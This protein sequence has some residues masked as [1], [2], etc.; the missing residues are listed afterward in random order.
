MTLRRG[1][2]GL[3]F[4]TT[5]KTGSNANPF[6]NQN[7]FPF[8]CLDFEYER[9]SKTE[10]AMAYRSGRHV[11]E[12]TIETQTDY[13]V[14]V[15]TQITNWHLTGLTRGQIE[16]TLSGITIPQTKR[17]KVNAAGKILDSMIT[18]NMPII[19]S[20]EAYGPWGQAG[21]IP[22]ASIAVAAGEIQLPTTLANATVTYM[23]DR[24]MT[25]AKG[26]GGPGSLTLMDK[27]QCV[28]YVKDNSGGIQ[29]SL[30]WIPQMYR[31]SLDVALK[32]TGKL[33]EYE[34]EFV[35]QIPAGWEE[36]DLEIDGQSI[37]WA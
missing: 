17:A 26:Y 31:K 25:T 19:A 23:F 10:D 34:M 18:A 2:T 24:T 9:K 21:A 1:L 4:A 37:V 8:P 33:I 6:L 20:I 29:D 30:I 11:I 16:R 22:T 35:P 28:A 3:D 14:K 5:N 36:P 7:V 32:F 15:K 13:T 27:F 12:E